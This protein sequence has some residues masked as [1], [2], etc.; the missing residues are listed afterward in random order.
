MLFYETEKQMDALLT[1]IRL[2]TEQKKNPYEGY[3]PDAYGALKEEW[4]DTYKI[5]MDREEE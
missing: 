4:M 3:H 2:A 5:F 1:L